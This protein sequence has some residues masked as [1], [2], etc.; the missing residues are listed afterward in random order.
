[1]KAPFIFQL[2]NATAALDP[3]SQ[4]N[5][6]LTSTPQTHLLPIGRFDCIPGSSI[7]S[8][9]LTSQAI[10]QKLKLKEAKLK[11]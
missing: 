1:M 10:Q 4:A 8:V 11:H 6:R 3:R 5:H 9:D 7:T 2:R